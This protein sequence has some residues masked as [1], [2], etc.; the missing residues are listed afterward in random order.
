MEI[1]E[2]FNETAKILIR[3]GLFLVASFVL[4]PI[5]LKAYENRIERWKSNNKWKRIWIMAEI[6]FIVFWLKYL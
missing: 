1:E 4:A 2:L 6:I 3:L 5:I